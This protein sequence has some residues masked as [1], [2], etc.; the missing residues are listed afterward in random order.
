[1]NVQRS[2]T[3]KYSDKI[4]TTGGNSSSQ[5]NLSTFETSDYNEYVSQ[6]K[7]KTPEDDFS[8][9][10]KEFKKEI[11]ELL[12]DFGNSQ[13]ENINTIKKDISSINEQLIEMKTKTDQ[14]MV[15]HHN[16]KSEIQNLTNT[17]NKNQEKIKSIENNVQALK[18]TQSASSSSEYPASTPIYGNI[19]IELQERLE[20]SKNIIITGISEPHSENM[21]EKRETDRC[22]VK[23]ILSDIYPTYPEP[24]KIIRL[25]KY[26]GKKTRPLKVCFSTPETAKI[27]LKNKLNCKDGH[28]KIYS[29]QTPNQKQDMENLRD[30]L[31]QRKEKGESDLIIK[32]IKGTPKIIKQGPKNEIQEKIQ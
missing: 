16:F 7:R 12:K 1:M 25:G 4:S 13:I 29:D 10:F 17:V 2:P 26:D 24:E 23:K 27:L 30:E 22:E 18:S 8:N 19:I 3:G 6:R 11:M 14:L 15:E 5:P 31:R 9:Q 21:E 28:I 32:Y 20:R